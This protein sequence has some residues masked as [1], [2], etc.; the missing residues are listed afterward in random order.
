MRAGKIARR[1]GRAAAVAVLVLGVSVAAGSTANAQDYQWDSASN[2]GSGNPDDYQ[3]DC[4]TPRGS[5][6][7]GTSAGGR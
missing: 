2:C 1:A 5:G 3:W 7:G 6:N 4:V